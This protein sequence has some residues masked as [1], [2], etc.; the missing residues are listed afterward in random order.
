M[1]RIRIGMFV[2][3]WYPNVDGVVVVVNNLLNNISEYADVTL[4]IPKM[5]KNI[6]DNNYPFK[7]IRIDSVKVPTTDYRLSLSDIKNK[8]IL[9]RFNNIDFDIIHIHSPFTLGRLGIQIA[10]IKNIP[11]IAT[12]HT[13]WDFEFKKYLK[14]DLLVK[15]IIKHLIKSYNNCYS[16]IAMNKSVIKVYQDYGFNGKYE[17]INNGTDFEMIKDK[18]KTINKIN[19]MYNL[20]NTDI[21]FL[22][23]G[24]II[25]IKNI[26]FILD[27]LKILKERN[28]K[29]KMIFVGEGPDSEKLNIKRREYNL[30]SDVLLLGKITDRELIKSLYYRADLFLFPSLFD[31]S[32]LVQ[33][34]AAS[35]ETPSLLIEGSVTAD[36]VD[37]NI[38]GFTVNENIEDYANRIEEILNNKELYNKV[39]KNARN[40]LAKPWKEIAKQTYNYYHKIIKEYNR[41]KD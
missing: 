17:I 15:A 5:E 41:K 34:E 16:C 28:F 12:M 29:F 18:N 8:E 13:R 33:K 25:S 2:D 39:K 31:T 38:N 19:T 11:V 9:N 6:D 21:L 1:N 20:K 24:R 3:S 10:K 26:F 7:V 35:Q 30:E 36:E 37:N 4:V 40:D 14:S 23:V 22:Y 32:S 27:V